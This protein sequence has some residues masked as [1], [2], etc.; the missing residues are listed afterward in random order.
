MFDLLALLLAISDA[1][2]A[3]T[4]LTSSIVCVMSQQSQ[5]RSRLPYLQ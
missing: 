2:V 1:P 3:V 4:L 5:R